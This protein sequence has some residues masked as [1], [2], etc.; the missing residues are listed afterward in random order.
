MKIIDIKSKYSIQDAAQV[1]QEG[2]VL[3]FPT[4]TV[5][6]I[7]CLLNKIAIRKLYKIK[8]RPATQPTAILMTKKLSSLIC[9]SGLR[10]IV[11]KE[12]WDGKM[13]VIFPA[14]KFKID[15]PKIILG[16]GKIGVRLPKYKWL[17]KLINIVGPIV[18]TS[19]NKKGE[20]P[21]TKFPEI[22]PELIKQA[23]LTI[24]TLENLSGTPSTVFDLELN[25]T[26]RE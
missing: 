2:G 16:D 8:N 24:K 7:G 15:C 13:T 6:G 5:Y 25:M 17:E 3:I 10:V 18:A 19:A 11:P 9:Y 12:F 26:L 14:E 4:D 1:L 22:S 20:R 23:D 21:P